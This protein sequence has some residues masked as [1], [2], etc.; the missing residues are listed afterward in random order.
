MEACVARPWHGSETNQDTNVTVVTGIAVNTRAYDLVSLLYLTC[1]QDVASRHDMYQI[2][3]VIMVPQQVGKQ[4]S[5]LKPAKA[6][7][8]WTDK[9][10]LYVA[11]KQ[12]DSLK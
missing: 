10:C 3:S 2:A 4:S 12:F 1:G 6:I 5:T 11:S 8:V 9:C 7:I